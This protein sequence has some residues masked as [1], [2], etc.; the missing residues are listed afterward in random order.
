[1]LNETSLKILRKLV[2]ADLFSNTSEAANLILNLLPTPKVL[3]LYL[4]E[5]L[6]KKV[7][8]N[9]GGSRDDT[10]GEKENVHKTLLEQ[11][12]DPP[13]DLQTSALKAIQDINLTL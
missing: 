8:L 5:A 7:L 12:K 6:P 4:D 2:E 3:G 11:S 13:L 10:Q 9:Q 1:M